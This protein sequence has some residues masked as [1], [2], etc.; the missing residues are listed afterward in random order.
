MLHEWS[1]LLLIIIFA[2]NATFRIIIIIIINNI[3]GH[4]KGSVFSYR[5]LKWQKYNNAHIILFLIV[6]QGLWNGD[7][8]K[9]TL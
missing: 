9:L 7:V 8:E 2:S 3:S 1:L 6:T 4:A 5:E